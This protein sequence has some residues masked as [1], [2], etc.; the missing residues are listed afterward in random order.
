[1]TDPAA[2]DSKPARKPAARKP[3]AT[4]AAGSTPA[5]SKP[6]APKAAASTPAATKAPAI[7]PTL[8]AKKAPA[9]APAETAGVVVGVVPVEAP[10]V[11]PVVAPSAPAGW[12]P[13]APGATAQRW[14]DGTRWTE[15]TWEQPV[16]VVVPQALRAPEGTSPGTAWIWILAATPVVQLLLLIP[17]SIFIGQLGSLNF[18]DPNGFLGIGTNPSY[19]IYNLLSFVVTIAFILLPIFD[20][21]ALKARGVP[22]PFSWAFSFFALAI[23]SPIVYV[24]GRSVVVKR[25][26]GKGL[27]PMWVFIGLAVLNFVVSAIIGAVFFVALFS[28]FGDLLQNANGVG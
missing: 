3:T 10:V 16:A 25:R 14:W 26:T 2:A 27:A 28:Q 12:Y 11:P 22:Q 17:L 4:P 5:S 20:W 19:L 18:N 9:A 7:K 13:T 24:I 21:R 15:H 23:S 8:R 1:V 6:A